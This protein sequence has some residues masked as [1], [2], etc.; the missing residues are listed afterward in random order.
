MARYAKHDYELVAKI[1]RASLDTFGVAGPRNPAAKYNLVRALLAAQTAQYREY[2]A[3]DSASFD[4]ERF[5]KAC[6]FGPNE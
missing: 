5:V 4:A 2:F 3:A 6:G 1:I